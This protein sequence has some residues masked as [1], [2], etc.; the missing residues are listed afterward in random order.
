MN[1]NEIITSLNKEEGILL[2]QISK[3]EDHGIFSSSYFDMKKKL[4]EV[5]T[6]LDA[7]GDAPRYAEYIVA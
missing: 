4:E 2:E 5:R 7:F 3:L 6:S 1:T